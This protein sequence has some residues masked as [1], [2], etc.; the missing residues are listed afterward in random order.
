MVERASK[1]DLPLALWDRSKQGGDAEVACTEVSS[2]CALEAVNA[3]VP[4]DADGSRGRRNEYN[5]AHMA[6]WPMILCARCGGGTADGGA[7]G[8][9]ETQPEVDENVLMLLQYL[10]QLRS[11]VMCEESSVPGDR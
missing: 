9:M 11:H 1:R 4:Q 3:T 6:V 10:Y 8:G 2:R 5:R 7:I